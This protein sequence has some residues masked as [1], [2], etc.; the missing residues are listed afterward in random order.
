MSHKGENEPIRTSRGKLAESEE[1]VSNLL[2]AVEH[3]LDLP[4]LGE[5]DLLTIASLRKT[6]NDILKLYAQEQYINLDYHCAYK[7]LLL[8]RM[9]TRELL[10]AYAEKGR[11]EEMNKLIILLELIEI[12]LSAVRNKYL[13]IDPTQIE[14]PDCPKCIEDYLDARNNSLLPS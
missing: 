12:D 11:T 9:Q 10:Q 4:Y 5:E 13:N 3:L 7:H 2:A 14:D 8:S 6:R 1:V